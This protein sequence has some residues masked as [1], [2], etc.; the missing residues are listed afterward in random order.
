MSAYWAL[1]N[2]ENEMLFSNKDGTPV[3]AEPIEGF[4][5]S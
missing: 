1:W 4:W 3:A 2:W 5:V